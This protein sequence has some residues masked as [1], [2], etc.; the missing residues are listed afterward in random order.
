MMTEQT[1]YKLPEAINAGD[2]REDD[3]LRYLGELR[4]VS[5]V[6]R[7]LGNGWEV[8]FTD[9]PSANLVGTVHVLR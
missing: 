2:L 3:R 1:T 7:S 8:T 5:A 6:Q 4:T 9:G